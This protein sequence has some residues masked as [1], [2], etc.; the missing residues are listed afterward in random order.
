MKKRIKKY[1]ILELILI[2][3]RKVKGF[4]FTSLE[5]RKNICLIFKKHSLYI[6]AGHEWEYL[7]K[8][9]T[10]FKVGVFFFQII[11][12]LHSLLLNMLRMLYKHRIANFVRLNLKLCDV[13]VLSHL[14]L[15]DCHLKGCCQVSWVSTA[16]QQ[17]HLTFLLPRTQNINK[18]M[19]RSATEIVL[20]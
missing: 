7:R 17:K 19:K 14:H 2:F 8:H 13:W 12:N 20:K 6:T 15:I 10:R 16:P 18:Q 3:S 1:E 11:L 9:I 5:D 4:K